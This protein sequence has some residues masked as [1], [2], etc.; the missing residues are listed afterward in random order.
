MR[1][2]IAS[3]ARSVVSA[4]TSSAAQPRQALQLR[5]LAAVRFRPRLRW[6]LSGPQHEQHEHGGGQAEDHQRRVIDALLTR[7]ALTMATISPL[8]DRASDARHAGWRASTTDASLSRTRSLSMTKSGRAAPLR[9]SVKIP[10]RR[11]A[12]ALHSPACIDHCSQIAFLLV[13]VMSIERK[14]HISRALSGD[15]EQDASRCSVSRRGPAYKSGRALTNC[16][17]RCVSASRRPSARGVHAAPLNA[18][19][20]WLAGPAEPAARVRHKPLR[21]RDASR[22]QATSRGRNSPHD[23]ARSLRA[24]RNR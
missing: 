20:R 24:G 9:R 1:L 14:R 19:G 17:T 5:R 2:P 15:R 12:M 23:G 6:H 22:D 7:A 18:S 21:C 16:R 8:D 13:P 4:S 3:I 10:L 11:H